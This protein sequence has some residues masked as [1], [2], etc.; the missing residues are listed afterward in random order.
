MYFVQERDAEFQIDCLEHGERY[1]GWRDFDRIPAKIRFPLGLLRAATSDLNS[2]TLEGL[3]EKSAPG[4]FLIYPTAV[5]R[6][7]P[8]RV[9]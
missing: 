1:P 2:G 5:E 7:A 6:F 9:P 8:K 3:G 4:E